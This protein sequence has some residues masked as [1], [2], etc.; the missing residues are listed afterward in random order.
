MLQW[1]D[2]D[3][4]RAHDL[5]LLLVFQLLS[6]GRDSCRML[7]KRLHCTIGI[8]IHGGLETASCEEILL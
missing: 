7:G 1:N 4:N 3:G 5:I 6:F 8:S 2:I